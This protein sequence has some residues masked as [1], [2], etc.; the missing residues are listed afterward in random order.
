MTIAQHKIVTIHYTVVDAENEEVID[1][2]ENGDP[3]IYLHGANNI[4]PGLNHAH[5]YAAS[6]IFIFDYCHFILGYIL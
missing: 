1:S 5:L 6:D 4:I 3:M 2:S